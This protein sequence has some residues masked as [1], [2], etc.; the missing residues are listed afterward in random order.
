MWTEAQ[1]QKIKYFVQDCP[2]SCLDGTAAL[3]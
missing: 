2:D 1:K 3:I